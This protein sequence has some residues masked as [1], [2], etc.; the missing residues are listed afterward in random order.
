[1]KNKALT[2]WKDKVLFTPGPLTTSRTVK[3][4]MLRDLGSRD[5]EF[6][7]LVKDIRRRLLELGGVAD[8]KYETIIMQGS[9]T[10]GLEAVISSTIPPSGKLLVI[11]N[12]FL[13]YLFNYT[14]LII[15]IPEQTRDI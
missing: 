10:F 15:Y 8:G 14:S 9:G 6:I 11:I 1:M 12:I 5:F 7:G 3:Q 2:G 13:I 4:V